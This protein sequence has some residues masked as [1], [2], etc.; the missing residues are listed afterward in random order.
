LNDIA[1]AQIEDSFK[2]DL[3]DPSDLES[4]SN[5]LIEAKL[6]ILN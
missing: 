5:S 6:T 4:I 2:S 3:S 1:K